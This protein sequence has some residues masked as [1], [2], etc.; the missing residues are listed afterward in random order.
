MQTP[1]Q[2]HFTEGVQRGNYK[3]IL[4]LAIYLHSIQRACA[5]ARFGT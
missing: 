5:I 1:G 2:L 4:R 3:V